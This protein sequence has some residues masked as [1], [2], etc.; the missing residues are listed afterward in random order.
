MKTVYICGDSFST[1]DP[2]YGLCWVD[3]LQHN[4]LGLA[5]VVNYSSVAA[6]N[7]LISVQ[8]DTAINHAADFV[9]VQ[10]TACTR[11]EVAVDNTQLDLITRFDTHELVSYSIYRPYR[12]H[13][14]PA[15]QQLVKQYHEQFFDLSLS[16]YKDR[17]II[18]NTLQKL[19]DTNTLFLFDQGGFEH[20]S[21][22]NTT[23]QEYFKKYKDYCSDINL[24]DY[25]NTVDERPYY[26]IADVRVHRMVS[27][28]YTEQIKQKL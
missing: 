19:V 10:G 25:G 6:S 17:C 23:G 27:A 11:G 3:M 22:G 28:Y 7:L 15:Q 26:H 13:L 16:I 1:P 5:K 21:F 9:I 14:T 20:A 4:L 24:W 2:E 8:V 18:E 12:S